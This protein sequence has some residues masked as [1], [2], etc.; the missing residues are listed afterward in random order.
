MFPIDLII[1][2]EWFCRTGRFLG[3]H[4]LWWQEHLEESV[5]LLYHIPIAWISQCVYSFI[6]WGTVR[7]LHYSTNYS[8]GFLVHLWQ[9]SPDVDCWIMTCNFNFNRVCQFSFQSNICIFILWA[10]A[11]E[12]SCFLKPSHHLV[13]SDKTV[14]ILGVWNVT[15]F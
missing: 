1:S 6:Y 7:F 10:A 12:N 15:L 11:N 4:V 9:S 8:V 5:D 13:V 14:L 3:M 2:S